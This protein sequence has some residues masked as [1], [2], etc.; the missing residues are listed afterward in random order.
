VP[1]EPVNQYTVPDAP[2]AVS[3]TGARALLH[4]VFVLAVMDVGL[5]GGGGAGHDVHVI[6][7]VPQEDAVP[8]AEFVL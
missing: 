2:F 4:N 1:H 8:H 6:V 7:G 3:V 5:A